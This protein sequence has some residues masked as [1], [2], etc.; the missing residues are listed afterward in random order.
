[1]LYNEKYFISS[2]PISFNLATTTTTTTTKITTTPYF[3]SNSE[4][5]TGKPS[6]I[7]SSNKPTTSFRSY[8]SGISNFS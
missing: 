8:Y 2:E 4:S 7:T 5:V 6:N 1:M 3:N